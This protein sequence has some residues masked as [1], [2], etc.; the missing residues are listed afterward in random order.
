MIQQLSTD[1]A[2]KATPPELLKGFNNAV[3]VVSIIRITI[4]LSQHILGA[5]IVVNHSLPLHIAF[6]IT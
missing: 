1:P 6:P 2:T 3:R 4:P 5:G